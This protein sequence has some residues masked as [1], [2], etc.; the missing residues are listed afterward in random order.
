[1]IHN[2][3]TPH[4]ASPKATKLTQHS[5]PD[6]GFPSCAKAA[7]KSLRRPLF[8]PF[9]TTVMAGSTQKVQQ[10]STGKS[11]EKDPFNV[12]THFWNTTNP[13][14]WWWKLPDRKEPMLLSSHFDLSGA[15]SRESA[16]SDSHV[17]ITWYPLPMLNIT[18][19][20]QWLRVTSLH[21]AFSM[22]SLGTSRALEHRFP[23]LLMDQ[24]SKGW[25]FP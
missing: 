20:I 12:S 15:R 11:L 17:E 14:I 7:I 2:V 18:Q 13:I 9:N 24:T 5:A 19:W 6:K 4:W 21:T 16:L 1:M 8:P 25:G 22:H 23:D 3:T 10:K